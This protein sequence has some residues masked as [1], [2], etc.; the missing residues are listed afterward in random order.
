MFKKNTAG[1]DTARVRERLE[2][3]RKKMKLSLKACAHCT[4]CAES[5]F[6][7]MARDKDPKY[8]PSYKFINSIGILYKT[9]GNV[10]KVTL[11]EIR[12][13]VWERCALCTRCYCPLGID[14]PEMIALARSIC[15]EQGVYPQYDRE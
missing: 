15:R 11:G 8:T 7:Y 13:N 1:V 12:D 10:D 5:C 14:I 3:H 4:L 6:L 2:K 9:N